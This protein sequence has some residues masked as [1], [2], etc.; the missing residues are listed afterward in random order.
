[1]QNDD[2]SLPARALVPLLRDVSLPSGPAARARDAA[3]WTGTSCSTRTRSPPASTRCGSGGCSPTRASGS[4]PPRSASIAGTLVTTKRLIDWLHAPDGRF[5]EHP[6]QARDALLALSLDEAVAELTQRFGPDP[7]EWK[8]GQER[9]HH[10][11][12]DHPLSAV[13]NARRARQVVRRPAAA[14]RRRLDDQRHRQRRQPDVA[15]ARSRSS[16]TPKTGTTRS[17]STRQARPATPTTRTTA[18]SSSSGRAAGTSRSP[19]RAESGIGEGKRRRAGARAHDDQRVGDDSHGHEVTKSIPVGP[20]KIH[21]VF[22][23]VP[24]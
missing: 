19:T 17:A 8:Y 11:L 22:S 16:R 14:R 6:T 18:I 3:A 24:S 9:F 5:G 12:I 15:A 4:C 13:V 2:L 20:A 21:F 23:C 10:A 1:M 7:Q